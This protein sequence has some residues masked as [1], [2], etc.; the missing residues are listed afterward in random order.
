MTKFLSSQMLAASL[1]IWSLISAGRVWIFLGAGAGAGVG[2]GAGAEAFMGSVW[3][4]PTKSLEI[5]EVCF[6]VNSSTI[7]DNDCDIVWRLQW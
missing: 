4:G 3:Q 5:R 7:L 2:A 1:R 6:V